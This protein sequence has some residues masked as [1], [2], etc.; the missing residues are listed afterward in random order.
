M[1]LLPLFSSGSSFF[2]LA[3]SK[4]SDSGERCEVKKA[5]KSRGG[6]GREV[7][8]PSLTSPPPS[9][10]F[11]SRSFLLRT[12]PHYLNAWNRLSFGWFCLALLSCFLPGVRN[13]TNKFII[14][15]FCFSH[16]RNTKRSREITGPLSV[17]VVESMTFYYCKVFKIYDAPKS[18]SS[19]FYHFTYT[20]QN[21]NLA[22]TLSDWHLKISNHTCSQIAGRGS[23]VAVAG[24]KSRVGKM[25]CVKFKLEFEVIKWKWL[26]I[27]KGK[28]SFLSTM[29]LGSQFTVDD[30]EC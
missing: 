29:L 27:G 20:T 10:L 13:A 8:V 7:R 6:L 17:V 14:W 18:T 23:K 2:W 1:I 16:Q 25:I 30:I 22:Q 3:C 5:I 12:A 21:Y 19:N 9:L 11:F 24:P 4:R 28:K 26:I 15:P